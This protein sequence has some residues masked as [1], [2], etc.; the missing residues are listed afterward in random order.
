M[1]DS[2]TPRTA[3]PCVAVAYSG[4][5]DSTA[6]L[7]ATWRQAR[8]GGLRVVALHIHH[9]LMT[10]ADGWLAHAQA[11]CR[12][13]DVPLYSRCLQ[14]SPAPGDSI[15][16]WARHHRY[17]ALTELARSAGAE[18]VLLAQHAEDQ[19][20]SVL[21]QALRGGGPAGLAAMPAHWQTGGLSWA[22]PWLTRPR[23]AVRAVLEA[24]QLS[25]VEDP[26]NADPRFARS[27]LRTH[28]MPVLQSAF[29][30]AVTVLGDV[31]RHAAQARLLADEIAAE[32]LPRCLDG[33]GRLL[34]RAWST[35]PPA[36]RHNV[37]R[38]WLASVLSHG[39]PVA[40]LERLAKE[41]HGQG[42]RWQAPGGWICARRGGLSAELSSATK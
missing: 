35:L 24:S 23:D 42:A 4:G 6:L 38:A 2:A 32:D 26:S 29:P 14:G 19:A 12:R 31:A 21:L 5:A 7:W 16:A 13:L 33:H 1:V 3:E 27:R 40:L 25:W 37:L 22:R 8:E 11:V 28:V 17:E 20:E 39:V 9:G 30:Q 10:E 36:R 34:F 41:W 18:L 15:E